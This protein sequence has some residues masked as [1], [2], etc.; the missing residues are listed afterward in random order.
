MAFIKIE[1]KRRFVREVGNES[2][3]MGAYL[4]EGKTSNKVSAKHINFRIPSAIMQ[5][6][7]IPCADGRTKLFIHEG[8]GEDAG[9][10]LVVLDEKGGYIASQ[11]KSAAN[12]ENSGFSLGVALSKF[13]YYTP[14][15]MPVPAQPVE[16]IF[17]DGG[18]LIFTPDWFRPNIEKMEEEGLMPL[19]EEEVA[20]IPV[21]EAI[22]PIP[23]PEPEPEPEPKRYPLA[24]KERRVLASKV[25]HALAKR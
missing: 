11:N 8:V 13:N 9:S 24:R 18:I 17:Q 25:A 20:L 19:P 15:E 23:E 21:E 14:N 3:T 4:G 22:L 16:H 5:E 2:I 12:G 1:Q 6:S 7:G 10:L